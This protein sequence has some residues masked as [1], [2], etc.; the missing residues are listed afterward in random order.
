MVGE[1][2]PAEEEFG[3][4]LV[5]ERL[6]IGGMATVHRALE[7]G[8]EGFER[9]VAL[10]RLL[11]HLAED[12]SFMGDTTVKSRLESLIRARTPLVTPE[13]YTLTAAGQRVL[14]G[15]IDARQLNGIDRWIGGV[16]LQA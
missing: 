9:M 1:P 5:Y 14:A 11:P 10:K 2:E 13:P 3:P 16:H 4:Y 8:I 6:G 12:A 15:E 7:R